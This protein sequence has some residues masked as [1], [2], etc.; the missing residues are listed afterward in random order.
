MMHHWP[1]LYHLAER[2]HLAYGFPLMVKEV[3]HWL[4]THRRALRALKG[5]VWNRMT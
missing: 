5:R 4:W 3:G 2:M 1:H